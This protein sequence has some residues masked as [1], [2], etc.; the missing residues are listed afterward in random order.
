M[1]FWHRLALR[2]VGYFFVVYFGA[3][4]VSDLSLVLV[5]IFGLFPFV[6]GVSLIRKSYSSTEGAR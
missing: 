4:L 6:V 5:G 3:V 2:Y 1:N